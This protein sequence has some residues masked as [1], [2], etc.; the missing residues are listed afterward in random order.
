[1]NDPPILSQPRPRPSSQRPELDSRASLSSTAR[2]VLEE[3]QT[4]TI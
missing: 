3:D 4:L 1:M 2:V